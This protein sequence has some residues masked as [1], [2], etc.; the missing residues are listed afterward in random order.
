MANLLEA[1][2]SLGNTKEESNPE[3]SA[4]TLG[5]TSKALAYCLMASCNKPG[6][7]SPYCKIRFTN[8]TSTAPAPGNSLESLIKPLT[9]ATPSS[10]ALSMSSKLFLVA[11]LTMIVEVLVTSLSCLKIVTLSP[12]ISLVS[13]TSM[14]PISSGIGAPNLVMLGQLTDTRAG[15]DDSHAGIVD[16]F[17]YLI[18]LSF[19][20]FGEIQHFLGVMQQHGTF[21]FSLR[22]I[23]RTR[24]DHDLGI[25]DVLDVAFWFVRENHTFDN[26]RV[27]Q[28][29]THDLHDSDTVNVEGLRVLWWD[30]VEDGFADQFSKELF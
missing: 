17:H 11:P 1:N 21:G 13:T 24:E 27:L 2:R 5:I 8:S 3:V 19:F 23:E 25:L 10:M 20:T 29:T 16:L 22:Y 30:H 28:G 18:Q 7:L 26:L 6:V 15:N 4:R 9:E 12:P 14:D